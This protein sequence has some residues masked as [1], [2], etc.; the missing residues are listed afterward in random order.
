MTV[1]ALDPVFWELVSPN[2]RLRKIETGFQFLEGPV[3][4]PEKR[5]LIFSDIPAG[6]RWQWDGTRLTLL[7]DE[8]HMGNGMTLDGD[9]NLLVCEHAT[10]IVSRYDAQGQRQVLTSHYKGQE[11]NSPNDICIRADGMIYFT[12]P[13]YGRMADYGIERPSELDWQGVFRLSLDPKSDEP[14]LLVEKNLFTMPNGLCFAPDETRFYVN[15]SEQAN[16][17]VFDVLRDGNLTNHRLFAEGIKDPIL[18]GEPDGM[19]CDSKGNVWVTAPGGLWV[20]TEDGKKIGT[21]AVPEL[22]GNFHWGGPDWRSLF[23]CATTSLYALE[24]K[25]GPRVEP[26]MR[27]RVRVG[28]CVRVA[29]RKKRS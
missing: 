3:W 16:I 8:T 13:T 25:V 4:H 23:I 6:R 5:A 17:R 21:L 9:H 14:L 7:S 12:D 19:K 29:V 24:V 11:L 15:D 10:S 1:S 18:P 27:G 20:Y 2:A 28:S 22:V 26:F